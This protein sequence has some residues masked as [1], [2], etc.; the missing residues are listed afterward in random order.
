M[1][2]T[3]FLNIAF[4]DNFMNVN[5]M[6]KYLKFEWIRFLNKKRYIPIGIGIFALSVLSRF[7]PQT[8][9]LTSFEQVYIEFGGILFGII[10]LYIFTVDLTNGTARFIQQL[11][12]PSFQYFVGQFF[13]LYVWIAGITDLIFLLMKLQLSISTNDFIFALFHINLNLLIILLIAEVFARLFENTIVSIG[14]YFVLYLLTIII[15]YNPFISSHSF[16]YLFWMIGLSGCILMIVSFLKR[17][18]FCNKK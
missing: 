4:V 5:D 7:T 15:G 12:Y 8:F 3:S 6:K 11:G 17:K 13:V 9:S 16:E 14:I 1:L 2:K 18:S 10:A